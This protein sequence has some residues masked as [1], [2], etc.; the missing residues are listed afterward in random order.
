MWNSLQK[1]LKV[2]MRTQI[3]WD[4]KAYKVK[5]VT[6]WDCQRRLNFFKN[7]LKTFKE[8]TKVFHVK[9]YFLDIAI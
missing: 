6:D 4:I 8:V 9:S 3:S 7:I 2:F 5:K 1:T